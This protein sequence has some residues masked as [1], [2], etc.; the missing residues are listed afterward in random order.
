M[1]T[2]TER[3]AFL[4]SAN[5][6]QAIRAFEKTAN[7]ADKEL[8]KTNKSIGRVANSMTSL[9]ARGL[10]ST[11]VLAAGLFKASQAAAEDE[12]SQALLATQL[13]ATTGAT[14]AQVAA[15]EDYIDKTARAT[16]VTDDQLRPAFQTLVRATG[17]MVKS[18]KLL[19]LAMDI[20]AG[21]GKDVGAVTL[22]LSKAYGGNIGALTRLGVPLDENIKKSKDFD[23]AVT[24]LSEKFAGQAATAADTFAGRMARTRVAV[25]EAKEEIGRAFIPVL[26]TAAGAVTSASSKFQSLNSVTGGA[27][28]KLAAFGTVG[29]G[30]VST[31]S[32]VAGQTLKMRER[33]VTA[34]GSLTKL[35]RTAKVAGS[36]LAAI[37][38]VETAGAAVAQ[39]GG[40]ARETDERLNR[41]LATAGKSGTGTEEITTAF[42]ELAD[43]LKNA[44]TGLFSVFKQFGKAIRIAGA[45]TDAGR[46]AIEYLDE[47]FTDIASKSPQLAQ[48]IVDALRA[49]SAALDKNSDTYK[50]N[51]MLVKR[52]QDQLKGMAGASDALATANDAAASAA[53]A[54]A[55]AE[56]KAR[57]AREAAKLA[58]ER[59]AA[60]LK[61]LRRAIGDDFT[62]AVDKANRALQDSKKAYDTYARSVQQSVYQVFSFN[63]ALNALRT[64]SDKLAE[65]QDAVTSATDTVTQAQRRVRDTTWA[66]A[67]AEKDLRDARWS[68]DYGAITNAERNLTRAREDATDAQDALTRANTALSTATE[69]A[70]K[71][72]AD[73]GKSFLDRLAEQAKTATEFGSKIQQLIAMDIS[74]DSLQMILD[75][76]AE[77]GG[78][79]ADELIA[80]GKDAVDQADALTESVKQAAIRTG[81]D[82][83]NEY[84]SQGVTL[85]TNLVNG[86]NSVV[87][88]YKVKLSSKGLTD[89]Q[90]ATLKKRFAVDVGFTFETS[91]VEIPELAQGGIVPATRGGRLVRVAEAGQDEAIIPL[92]RMSSGGGDTYHIEVNTG[93]GDPN[94]IARQVV[95]AL[96]TYQRRAGAIPIKVA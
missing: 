66:V 39:L 34:E 35:G 59:Y 15:V 65:S 3:L 21:T 44:D 16:G 47:A 58:A 87:K 4:V 83:A 91:G 23:A 57:Q 32:L 55:A 17:S 25:D 68:G 74:Q 75:A 78:A 67:D 50:D 52:Y 24:A 12:K 90:L 31:L 53:A 28:G 51:M 81:T 19:N 85:A 54:A 61:E 5:A 8:T 70:S 82:A 6:D 96:Q 60:R 48:T 18:Q 86:I 93:I 41:L 36:A 56:E 46:I 1:A 88:N 71:A 43:Q 95:D 76:G 79:I 27:A 73:S 45:D 69:T 77:A 42:A 62:S 38:V 92:P 33:F 49:Q 11:G 22:A 13:K 72:A 40:F 64:S 89:K 94:A 14:D 37:A 9:G 29:L 80:G 84:Y 26:Q 2:I 10:A 20:S 7:T 30:V 63:N